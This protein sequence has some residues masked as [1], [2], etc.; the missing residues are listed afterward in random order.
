M[1]IRNMM[2]NGIYRLLHAIVGSGQKVHVILLYHSVGGDAPN[3]IPISTFE[4]QMAFLAER[5]RV[6][7][8]RRFAETTTAEPFVACVTFDEGY[9]DN[10]EVALPILE[11]LGVEATFFVAT[12]FLGNVF[13]TFAKPV[14]MMTPAQVRELAGLGHEIGAHTVTHPRLTK[15]PLPKARAEMADSKKSLEDLL[16]TE[17]VSF[18]YPKGDYNAAIKDTVRAIGFRFAVTIRE[19]LVGDA[20]DWLT[21]PRVWISDRLSMN[22]FKAKVSPAAEMYARIRERP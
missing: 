5:F 10:R 9:R 15:V 4:R 11:W 13:Q 14:P 3:S 22:T 17:V 21:L 18:A 1:M 6:V 12:G 8:L 19:G 20:P 7:P 16:G 2:R